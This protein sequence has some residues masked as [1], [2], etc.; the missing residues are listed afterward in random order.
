M[1]IKNY[2]EIAKDISKKHYG[3][4]DNNFITLGLYQL[5]QNTALKETYGDLH[6]HQHADSSF[7]LKR[8]LNYKSHPEYQLIRFDG[9]QFT[10][11]DE[12]IDKSTF[13]NSI[14]TQKD[15]ELLERF[16]NIVQDMDNFYDLQTEFSDVEISTAVNHLGLLLSH[17]WIF[18]TL[19]QNEYNLELNEYGFINSKPLVQ[20]SKFKDLLHNPTVKSNVY[21]DASLNVIRELHDFSLRYS[22]P[23]SNQSLLDFFEGDS[24]NKILAVD[25][26]LHLRDHSFEELL[27]LAQNNP[28]F[29]NTLIGK[30]LTSSDLKEITMAFYNSFE[31]SNVKTQ[32]ELFTDKVTS[33]PV[34]EDILNEEITSKALFELSETLSD[35]YPIIDYTVHDVDIIQNK[36]LDINGNHDSITNYTDSFYLMLDKVD[37]SDLAAAWSSTTES[38]MINFGMYA[39]K[40]ELTF[41]DETLFFVS[42]NQFNADMFVK[43]ELYE[44]NK[45]KELAI[46]SLIIKACANPENVKSTF[47]AVFDYAAKNEILVNF[48]LNPRFSIGNMSKENV[49]SIIRDVMIDYK[50]TVLFSKSFEKGFSNNRYH[51][52]DG[53]LHIVDSK[54]SYRERIALQ[55][56]LERFVDSAGHDSIDFDLDCK[57]EQLCHQAIQEKFKNKI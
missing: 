10:I 26:F 19:I 51:L 28:L 30:M 52:I 33:A 6:L 21:E 17:T 54:L 34:L 5:I 53:P 43:C 41:N 36:E 1:K 49:V 35:K 13:S 45:V 11:R 29:E 40:L 18:H 38:Y 55:K 47:K 22:Y 20:L 25:G 16:N 27:S 46:N 15:R 3:I 9:R 7:S 8:L 31:L 23:I 44:D 50:D 39:D 12:E 57:I 4:V 56:E 32:V 2:I 42:K 48:S 14:H 37:V 24:L